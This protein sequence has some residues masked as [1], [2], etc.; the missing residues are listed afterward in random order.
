M[1]CLAIKD[2]LNVLFSLQRREVKLGLDHTYSLLNHLQNPEKGL[3]MIHIAGTNGKGSTAAFISSI[4]IQKGYR[5]GV[6][7]SPHLIKFNERIR[8]NGNFITDLEILEFLNK[9]KSAIKRIKSTFFETTTAMALSYFESKDV[10][11]AV[12]ETGLGGRLDSTNVIK[13]LVSVIT[14][15]SLDHMDLLGETVEKIAYEKAG[16]IKKNTPLIVGPNK[17]SVADVFKKIAKKKESKIIEIDPL[18][19]VTVDESGTKFE[20]YDQEFFIPLIGNHQAQ[21]ASLA[22]TAARYCDKTITNALINRGLSKVK[23]AGR[24]HCVSKGVFYDVAHNQAGLDYLFGT[25]RKVFPNRNLHGLL[26]LKGDKDIKNIA[27]Q[28]QNRFKNLFVSC[29]RNGFLMTASELSKKLDAL[30]I[31]NIKDN[32]IKRCIKKLQ[33]AQKPEDIIL[34]FGTHYIAEE[35]FEEFEIPFDSFNI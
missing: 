6:F 15:I 18:D 12:I 33:A 32:S 34:I 10:D 27:K 24:L 4:L 11:F 16:I 23:W 13:P 19:K 17:K 7:T 22:I 2:Q 26:C 35:V 30:S 5:V 25:I 9:A 1:N 31:N 8:V 3:K 20:C 21:N 28:L 29:D 14:S